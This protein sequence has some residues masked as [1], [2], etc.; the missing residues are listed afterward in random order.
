YNELNDSILNFQMELKTITDSLEQTRHEME[1]RS[2]TV[3][4]TQPLVKLKDTIKRL[5]AEMRQMDLR[6]GIVSHTLLQ[7]HLRSPAD[8][9]NSGI[10]G[11]NT[12]ENEDEE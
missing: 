7:T 1:Q 10:L 11:I 12:W 6:I 5:K 9:E 3:T 4:D 2:S 8:Q